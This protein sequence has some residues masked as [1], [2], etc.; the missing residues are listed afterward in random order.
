MDSTRIIE[1]VSYTLPT[2]IMGFVLYHFIELYTNNEKEKERWHSE[3]FTEVE[4]Y[5]NS[6]HC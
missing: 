4:E 2:L 6:A 3:T 1:L 5:N